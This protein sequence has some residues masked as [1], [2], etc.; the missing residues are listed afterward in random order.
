MNYRNL[1]TP[2]ARYEWNA[3]TLLLLEAARVFD[4]EWRE[5]HPGHTCDTWKDNTEGGSCAHLRKARAKTKG[6]LRR[7]R[8]ECLYAS[9]F[10]R[11]RV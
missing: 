3:N 6:W 4:Q 1:L 9:P 7:A 5:K 10:I 2:E 11:G 8:M